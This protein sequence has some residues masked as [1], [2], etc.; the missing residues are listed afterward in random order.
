MDE[1]KVGIDKLECFL[2]SHG[3]EDPEVIKYLRDVQ[4]MRSGLVAHRKTSDQKGLDK[5]H[6]PFTTEEGT[7]QIELEQI[8]IGMVKTLN[9]LDKL[10]L[11]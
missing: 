6:R 8:F 5:I 2:Y 7:Q 1:L 9:T 11:K 10:Y 4:T 3:E